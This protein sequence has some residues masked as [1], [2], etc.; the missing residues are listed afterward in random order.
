M[1]QAVSTTSPI[2]TISIVVPV[3]NEI[4]FIEQYFNRIVSLAGD[5]NQIVIVDGKSNDGTYEKLKLMLDN[6][7]DKEH[8]NLYQSESG[9]AR[10][11]NIGVEKSL[12]DAIIFLHVD[13]VLPENGI[14]LVKE[15]IA[16]GVFWG[17]FD[18]KID[19]TPFIYRLTE[20]LMNWRSALTSIA[21][22]DQAIFVKRDVFN[23]I[24]GFPIMP[25]MED[26]A[27]S[28]RL[29]TVDTAK[30]IKS[31]V[32]TS[33][34]RWQENGVWSTILL[35]WAIRLAYWSGIK[36]ERLARWYQRAK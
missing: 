7:P 30:R 5:V 22:G 23:M 25:L 21:T 15:S 6:H 31:P 32:L 20:N 11:M 29:K 28:V 9:R 13:T 35:M 3:Y 19:A 10:Q 34:R 16:R 33:A 24:G 26:I 2:P 17:R 14:L 1:I 27:I 4:K 12:A 18:V 36:P 8:I